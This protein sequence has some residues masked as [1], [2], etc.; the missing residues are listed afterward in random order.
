MMDALDLIGKFPRVSKYKVTFVDGYRLSLQDFRDD[1]GLFI[2][3]DRLYVKTVLG[4]EYFS[5]SFQT[6]GV[7]IKNGL[8]SN[9]YHRFVET[10]LTL[11]RRK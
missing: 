5:I 9:A 1:A 10:Y 2:T 11:S 8:V 4:I 7:V 3:G 6:D